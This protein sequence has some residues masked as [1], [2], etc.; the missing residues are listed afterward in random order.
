MKDNVLVV[1][2]IHLG[3]PVSKVKA[4]AKVL[5]NE[6]YSHLI[7]NGDLFDSKNIH[8]YK[9]GHWNILSLIRK[10]SKYYCNNVKGKDSG[11]VDFI[12]HVFIGFNYIPKVWRPFLLKID[13]G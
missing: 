9:K 6:K 4:L 7:I 13:D 11:I 3:S 5:K 12:F 1:S 10:V 8:R 2:D